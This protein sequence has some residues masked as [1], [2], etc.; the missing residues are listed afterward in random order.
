MSQKQA[1][2]VELLRLKNSPRRTDLQKANRP[3][4][5]LLELFR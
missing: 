1:D 5:K 2:D 4:D 3:V